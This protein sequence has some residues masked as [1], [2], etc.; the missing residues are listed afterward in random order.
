MDM[1]QQDIGQWLTI[2]ANRNAAGDL[3]GAEGVCRTILASFPDQ[4][5]VLHLLGVVLCRQGRLIEGETT[6]R[7]ALAGRP[8]DAEVLRHLVDA[9]HAQGKIAESVMVAEKLVRLSPDDASAHMRLAISLQDMGRVADAVESYAQALLRQDDLPRGYLN[10]AGAL[11]KLGQLD[12]AVAALTRA[13]DQDPESE[14]A[15]LTL[16]NVLCDQGRFD[17]A[18]LAYDHALQRRPGWAEALTNVTLA[19]IRLGRFADAVACG[20]RAVESDAD[21]GPGWTNLGQALQ[22]T[23]QGEAAL[24]AFETAAALQPDDAMVLSNLAQAQSRQGQLDRSL[25][26]HAR[27]AAVGPTLAMVY[28]NW[29]GALQ[30]ADRWDQAEAAFRR[31]IALGPDLPEPYLGLGNLVHARERS[32][33]A[34]PTPDRASGQDWP[35]ALAGAPATAPLAGLD[36][37]DDLALALHRKAVAVQP[38]HGVAHFNLGV[39]LLRRGQY[40]EGWREYAWRFRDG[41]ETMAGR[42]FTRPEWAGEDFRGRTLLIHAEQG[43]GD[44][45]QF[46]RFVAAAAAR[47]GRVVLE[48]QPAL[49]RLL[50]HVPGAHQVVAAGQT[51]PP[52]DL[53]LPL[54]NLPGVLDLPESAFAETVP[55]LKAE[56]ALALR[57]RGRL[58]GKEPAVGLVWSGNSRHLGDRRRSVP[59]ATML[60]A[61]APLPVRLFSLQKNVRQADRDALA[62][63]GDRV[64]DL[65][66]DLTDFSATAAV[67]ES[68]DLVITVDTALAHLSGALGR[69]TWVLLPAIADW[70]WQMERDDSPWYPSARLFRQ[71]SAGDWGEVT[72]R[73]A[74][75]VAERAATFTPG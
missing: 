57:W 50:A 24:A 48:V 10:L 14:V 1:E 45:I 73:V 51:L 21:F 18:L 35:R 30:D 22:R 34:A 4:A 6:L 38:D 17:D 49:A 68:L 7:R 3:M 56:L 71:R 47:G 13:L 59:A 12:D 19:L 23:E 16:G 74:A 2:A 9:L 58:A 41:G 72:A 69:P 37:Q 60:A 33:A 32:G 15:Y 5:R 8:D 28:Y 42:G 65:A 11:H 40:R 64:V 25:Q 67:V 26:T 61:L 53:H 70:R 54:M 43:F 31:A 46:V 55:Y 52:F 63:H 36:D 29:G 66:A 39:L 62:A 27:A 75:A 20:R 44:T